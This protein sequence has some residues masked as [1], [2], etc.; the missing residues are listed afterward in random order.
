MEEV[1]SISLDGS[2]HDGHQ[3]MSLI[4]SVD[5]TFFNQLYSKGWIEHALSLYP[6][7]APTSIIKSVL[8]VC[9]HE[10]VATLRC[11]FGEGGKSVVKVLGTTF[12]GSPTRTTLGNTLRVMLYWG[13]YLNTVGIKWDPIDEDCTNEAFIYVSGDDCVIWLNKAKLNQFNEDF[14]EFWSDESRGVK[15]LGQKIT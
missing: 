14:R 4:E 1:A 10:K 12:S 2:N 6:N 15:G 11:N 8:K 9:T 5:C 3:H 13:Y 7:K